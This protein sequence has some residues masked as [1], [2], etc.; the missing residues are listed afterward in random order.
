MT[1]MNTAS[2]DAAEAR[3]PLHVLTGFLGS[4]KSTLLRRQLEA[5]GIGG[6]P[7]IGVLVNEV[8]DLGIDQRLYE[9]ID[10]DVLMLPGGC[11][12]CSLRGDLHAAVERLAALGIERLVLETTGLADPAPLL[13]TIGADPRLGSLVELASVVAVVDCERAENLLPQHA[14]FRRQLDF[15]DRIVLS[16]TDRAPDREASVRE[17][18]AAEAPG[19]EVRNAVAG[20]VEAAWLFAAPGFNAVRGGGARGWLRAGSTGVHAAYTAHA[21]THDAPVHLDAVQLWLRLAAQIDGERLLRVKLIV[22]SRDDGRCWALQS[23]GR[24]VS[25]PQRLGVEP[26]GLAG[27]EGI[28]IE[29]GL[30]T[31]A[32][33]ALL[34]SLR[35]ALATPPGG[36]R[37]ASW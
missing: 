25:P 36:A 37:E 4:G 10:E 21:V 29:R 27:A 3:L 31:H 34:S 8:A 17:M 26:P 22:R 1:A 7:R 12:C 28:V 32:R 18:L 14:E 20:D 33:V 16:K 19:R 11:V 30:P 24:S 13:H 35:Q 2:A 9:R 15:A 23:A 5:G 6:S